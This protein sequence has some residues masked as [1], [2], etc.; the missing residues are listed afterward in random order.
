VKVRQLRKR[1]PVPA[2]AELQRIIHRQLMR[3]ARRWP[4]RN[5]VAGRGRLAQAVER[6]W[7][8]YIQR[9]GLPRGW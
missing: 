2:L 1:K 4:L 9:H 3:A 6:G 8:E 5:D 7:L